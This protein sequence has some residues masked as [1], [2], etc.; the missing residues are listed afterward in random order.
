MPDSFR[1]R[2][3]TETRDDHARVDTRFSKLDL[4]AADGFGEFLSVHGSCFGV[5]HDICGA[6]ARSA[7]LL[8]ALTSAIKLDLK[9]LGLPGPAAPS[10]P[11]L[12]C[13]PI[14][15]DYMVAGSRLGSKVLK[16]NWAL[17][18]DARVKAAGA[19][20]ALTDS[21]TLWRETCADLDRIDPDSPRADWVIADVRSLF[22][23]FAT[24]H[25]SPIPDGSERA[26]LT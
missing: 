4:Q 21:G 17:S 26:V 1:H 3:R 14:A 2:L 20:F 25:H 16:R 22:T 11:V 19:Y 23:L 15:I 18:A 6:A 24:T 7:A 12:G 5:M 9:S 8:G 13:D 10:E